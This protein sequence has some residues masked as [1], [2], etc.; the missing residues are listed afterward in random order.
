MLRAG[1]DLGT[2]LLDLVK[3]LDILS[4]SGIAMNA[5][6]YCDKWTTS[7]TINTLSNVKQ[8]QSSTVGKHLVWTEYEVS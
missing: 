4:Y 1:D 6:N 2:I 8:I 7:G 3:N 5:F